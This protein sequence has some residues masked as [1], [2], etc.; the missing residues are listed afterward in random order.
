MFGLHQLESID[1]SRSDLGAQ[2]LSQARERLDGDHS[3][4]GHSLSHGDGVD[5]G[6]GAVVDHGLVARQAQQR[7]DRGRRQGRQAGRVLETAGVLGVEG[8]GHHVATVLISNGGGWWRCFFTVQRFMALT[9]ASWYF[10]GKPA[11]S[12]SSRSIL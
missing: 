4:V 11:G 2:H 10:S 8:V 7:D 3:T 1:E 6:A 12:C 9:M 5:A